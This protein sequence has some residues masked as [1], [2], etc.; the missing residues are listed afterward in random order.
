MSLVG[1]RPLPIYEA[2]KLTCDKYIQ[3]FAAPSGITGLW[4]VE[5]RGG[6]EVSSDDR[7]QLDI[8]YA[9]R[10]SLWEDLKILIKTIPAVIQKANV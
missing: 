9:E 3:R 4:Q 7:K 5:G 1:N 10:Y 8:K 2:E 6:E